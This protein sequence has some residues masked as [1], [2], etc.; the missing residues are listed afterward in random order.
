MTTETTTPESLQL[1]KEY[2]S[3]EVLLLKMKADPTLAAKNEQN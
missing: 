3:Q 1:L 2:A